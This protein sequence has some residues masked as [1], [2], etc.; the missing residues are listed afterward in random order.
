MV[1]AAMVPPTLETA[2]QLW[3]YFFIA[4]LGFLTGHFFKAPMLI[5]VSVLVSVTMAVIGIVDGWPVMAILQNGAVAILLLQIMYVIGVVSH[6]R[7]SSEPH[8]N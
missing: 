7:D 2:V 8:D 5:A 6:R 3:N 1:N 4:L